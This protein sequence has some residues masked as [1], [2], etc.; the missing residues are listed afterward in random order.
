MASTDMEI[1]GIKTMVNASIGAVNSAIS[2]VSTK[3]SSESEK[4]TK[5]N[6]SIGE[7][8]E[9]IPSKLSEMKNDMDFVSF[10]EA[11]T[12]LEVKPGKA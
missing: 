12:Q 5:I 3:L 8:K 11:N 2:D 6:T 1:T 4:I 7:I 9:S 10:D